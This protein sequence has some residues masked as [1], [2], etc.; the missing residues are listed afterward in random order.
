MTACIVGWSHLPF[1]KREG[2]GAESLIV[3]AATAAIADAG[4]EPAEI[5]E[6]WLGHFNGGFVARGFTSSLV[7]QADRLAL[8]AREP[9]R[10][11]LCHRL[12]RGPSGPTRDRG[13]GG[14]DRARGRRREDDQLSGPAIG[15]T[16]L[17]CA[18]VDEEMGIE[19]G[20]AGVFGQIA[21][22]YFQRHGDQSDALAA[23]AAK[24][25][26]NGCGNPWAQLRKDLGYEFCRKS[27]TRTR[28]S[29]ARSSAPTV[30]WSPTALPPWCL[31]T[32]KPRCG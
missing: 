26:K 23:I 30:P 1:G 21:N 17:R 16:L 22:S 25:H 5:D 18:Y 13:Q 12:R 15:E 28:S 32:S 2:R 9:G 19:G 10:E 29:P 20:F 14:A 7:L 3:K 24:N 31:P 4:L 6:I 11:R 8:Q 27:R